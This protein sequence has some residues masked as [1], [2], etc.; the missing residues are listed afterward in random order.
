MASK[1]YLMELF[2][3]NEIFKGLKVKTHK[4][5]NIYKYLYQ[6]S[7]E[8]IEQE[9]GIFANARE[10][11]FIDLALGRPQSLENFESRFNFLKYDKQP[12]TIQFNNAKGSLLGFGDNFKNCFI[13]RCTML[14]S[15]DN[16]YRA[17][18]ITFME[19]VSKAYDLREYKTAL[20]NRLLSTLYNINGRSTQQLIGIRYINKLESKAM[21]LSGQFANMFLIPEIR[22]TTIGEFL[23]ANPEIIMKA[24]GCKNF[25]YEPE[26]EWIEGN[27]KYPEEKSINPDLMI[28]REDGFFDIVDLKTVI[29]KSKSITK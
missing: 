3:S 28:E 24:F 2:G 13:S 16:A 20:E 11:G 10:N 7:A 22:E 18:E 14:N 8:G 15:L 9:F 21:L 4:E 26:M 6:F 19:I 27:E 17:K 25:E 1:Y 23:K 5:Q 29:D 12:T